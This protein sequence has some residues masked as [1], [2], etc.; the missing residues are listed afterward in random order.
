MR[1]DELMHGHAL[2][3]FHSS[4]SPVLLC[5]IAVSPA[6]ALFAVACISSRQDIACTH[7]YIGIG[8]IY[9]HM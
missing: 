5:K 9:S 6:S 3:P 1:Q 2:H 4:S 7:T 8:S